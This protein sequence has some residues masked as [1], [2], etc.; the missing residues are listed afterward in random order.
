V[1]LRCA[2]SNGGW[3]D[4]RTLCGLL[5]DLFARVLKKLSD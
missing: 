4:Q 5:F 1:P 3:R 2:P